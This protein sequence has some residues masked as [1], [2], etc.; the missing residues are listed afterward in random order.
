MKTY[1]IVAEEPKKVPA[2]D[3]ENQP[4]C[5]YHSL[6][7]MGGI[8]VV[9][10]FLLIRPQQKR[11]KQEEQHKKDMLDNLQKNDQVTTVGGIHGIVAHVGE[12]EI[13]LKV[14]EKSDTRIRVS[15][16]AISRVVGDEE[17]EEQ[18]SK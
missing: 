2:D 12:D 11:R 4:P 8:F 7:L 15:R 3:Q 14:D 18:E 16:D 10:Y 9:F 13:T 17:E 5:S 1:A 6:I